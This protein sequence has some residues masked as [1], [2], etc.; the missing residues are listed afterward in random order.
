MNLISYKNYLIYTVIL[1][2]TLLFFFIK[3]GYSRA[4]EQPILILVLIGWLLFSIL[5]EIKK[6]KY[7]KSKSLSNLIVSFVY[8][9]QIYQ[10]NSVVSK[11]VL[12]LFFSVCLFLTFYEYIKYK[13]NK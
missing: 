2:F 9:L 10:V 1:I 7:S 8:L 3:F 5:Y 4:W 12:T 6:K 13:Q 11:L